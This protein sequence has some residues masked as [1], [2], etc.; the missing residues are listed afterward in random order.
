MFWRGKEMR[1]RFAI[2]LCVA[3]AF[4]LIL[5]CISV[6]QEKQTGCEKAKSWWQKLFNYPANVTNEAAGIASEAVTGAVGVVTKEVK[7]VGQVT[8]GDLEKTGDLVTEPLVG[9]AQTASKVI[10]GATAIPDKANNGDAK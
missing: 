9:T 10:E 6:A 4:C 3:L 2:V 8:S 5:S 7:A 1:K